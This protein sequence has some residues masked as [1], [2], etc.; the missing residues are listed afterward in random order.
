MSKGE[1]HH[2]PS[3]QVLVAILSFAE[4]EQPHFWHRPVPKKPA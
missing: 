1:G 3:G 2:L 4:V